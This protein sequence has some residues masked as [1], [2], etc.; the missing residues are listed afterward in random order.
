[1]CIFVSITTKERELKVWEIY[2][3]SL[4]GEKGRKNI[5]LNDILIA[6]S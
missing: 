1:M 3:R 6:N 5:L 4:G 2:R